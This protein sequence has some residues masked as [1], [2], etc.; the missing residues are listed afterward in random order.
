MVKEL[1]GL[2]V[3]DKFDKRIVDKLGRYVYVLV[4]P[5]NDK[6]QIFYVGKGKNGRVLDHLKSRADPNIRGAINDEKNRRIGKI[7]DG[8]FEP[9]WYV[10]SRNIGS[11]EAAFQ[12]EAALIY[13]I[14]TCM[15]ESTLTNILSGSMLKKHGG[16]NQQEVLSWSA[17]PVNPKRPFGQVLVFNIDRALKERKTNYEATCGKWFD[18]PEHCRSADQCLAVGLQEGISACVIKI[19]KESWKSFPNDDG[20]RGLRWEFAGKTVTKHEL[21]E[22]SWKSI[23]GDVGYW[24]F[25]RYL[26]IEFNGAGKFR[27]PN[28]LSDKSWKDVPATEIL[29][30]GKSN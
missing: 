16:A 8:G 27:F 19:D 15:K 11:D 1:N 25:G 5:T 28:S 22:K 10:V 2:V 30:Q 3:P 7:R 14:K 29:D 17:R 24:K 23:V 4:D 18:V 12:A 26:C 21:L 9:Q 13:S 6:N 20:K